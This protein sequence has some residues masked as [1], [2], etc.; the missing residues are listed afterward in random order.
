[1]QLGLTEHK[2]IEAIEKYVSTKLKQHSPNIPDG[3]KALLDYIAQERSKPA[4]AHRE[5]KLCHMLVQGDL[6]L[7]HRL[8]KR[9]PEDPGTMYAD[10]FRVMDGQIVE[11]W[12]VVQPVP[13]GPSANGHDMCTTLTP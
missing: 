7:I 12:D 4:A 1:M 11:H 6:V 8:V 13:P 3:K 9:G 2:P 5:S 10:L